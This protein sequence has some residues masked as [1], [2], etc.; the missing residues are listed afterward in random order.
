MLGKKRYDLV[1][2]VVPALLPGTFQNVRMA[3]GTQGWFGLG[4]SVQKTHC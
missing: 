1:V 2:A 4:V 3:L